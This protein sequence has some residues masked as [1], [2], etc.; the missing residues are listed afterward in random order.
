MFEGPLCAFAASLV[1]DDAR[2]VVALPDLLRREA[3][4]QQLLHVYGPA[5]MPDQLPVLVSQWFKFYCMQIIPPVTVASLAHGVGWP[6]DL[7]ALGFALNEQGVLDG[8]RFTGVAVTASMSHDPFKRFAPLLMNVQEVIDRLCQYSGLA[9][10]VLWSSAGDYLE[11]CLRQLSAR[12][13]VSLAPGYGLLREKLRP[14]GSPNPLFATI[15][16]IEEGHRLAGRRRRSCC[17]SYRVEWVG[18]CEHC[19]L[20]G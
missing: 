4:D 18:R 1:L 9:P 14:D 11:T 5:L 15:T 8:V 2:A 20:Q 6:L 7:A 17:L 12:S 3:L 10:G 19:P 13:D 16:Y